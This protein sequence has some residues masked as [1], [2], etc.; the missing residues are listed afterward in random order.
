MKI[1]RSVIILLFVFNLF[2]ALS[3]DR[4]P[5]FS[6]ETIDPLELTPRENA[7]AEEAALFISGE[8]VAPQDL[9]EKLLS[10]FSLLREKYSDSI[11]EVNIPFELS[12]AAE[13]ILIGLSDS[14]ITALRA[15]N[16]H[17]WDS[18]NTHYNYYL[19]DTSAHSRTFYTFIFFNGRYNMFNLGEL[20]KE[21][22]GI[23][24]AHGGM[25]WNYG[26][27][28][29]PWIDNTGNL[30]FLVDSAWGDCPSG[31][32]NSHYYYFKM[33]SGDL[34]YIGDWEPDY[35]QSQ[36]IPP[37]WW[38]EAKVAYETYWDYPNDPE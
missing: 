1:V 35:H 32:M 25:Y 4:K 34:E 11:P 2:F 7:E 8:L 16:Y 18:L 29:Y 33:L 19:I 21:L 28:T 20:Y 17:A 37:D 13:A 30:T 3:C 36:V 26:S 10:G 9:Y 23:S 15:G 27:R 24:Y 14:A 38:D 12:Y 31:C 6:D 5:T 22:P